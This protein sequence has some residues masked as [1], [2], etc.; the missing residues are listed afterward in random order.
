MFKDMFRTPPVLLFTLCVAISGLSIYLQSPHE[1]N[2]HPGTDTLFSVRRAYADLNEIASAPHS[3]GTLEHDKVMQ[4]IISACQ[5]AGLAAQIQHS[6]SIRPSNGAVTAADIHNIIAVRKG[7]NN[8]KAVLVMAHYDSQPNTFGAG[9]NGVGVAAMIETARVLNAI[10]Q[11]RNDVI[12]LF[13]DGEECGLLGAKAFIEESPLMRQLGIVLNFEGRG[14]S[15]I[16]TMFEVNP[17]NGWIVREYISGAAHPFANSLSFEIYK[18]LPNDTDYSLF[19]KAGISGLN[20]A[21][22]EGFVN[23]HSMTDSRE[24][25]DLNTLRQE[26][27]NM[28]SLVKHFGSINIVRTKEKD[29]SYFNIIGSYMIHYPSSWDLV[30]IILAFSV[31]GFQTIKSI[32]RGQLTIKGLLAGAGV[33]LMTSIIIYFLSGYLLGLFKLLSPFNSRFYA[34]NTYSS[35]YYFFS[36]TVF[37]VAVFALSYGYVSKKLNTLS[38]VLGAI[39][40]EA[41][42]MPGLFL[43]ASTASYFLCLPLLSVLIGVAILRWENTGEVLQKWASSVRQM[44]FSVIALLIMSP[45]IYMTYVAFGLSS[46]LQ[47]A[48]VMLCLLLGLLLPMLMPVVKSRTYLIPI[49]GLILFLTSISLGYF[50]GKFTSVQPLRTNLQYILNVDSGK[51]EWVSDFL[52]TD[53]WNHQFFTQARIHGLPDRYG[54]KLLNAAPILP[55]QP[56]NVNIQMDTV[57]EG[58][59]KLA[60]YFKPLEHITSIRVQI[61]GND[62]AGGVMINGKATPKGLGPFY[63][64][65]YYA[66]GK[67]GM[68]IEFDL[69]PSVKFEMMVIDRRIGIPSLPGYSNM[70]DNIVH[71]PS[72]NTS[73]VVKSYKL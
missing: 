49:A 17:A 30:F 10:G 68:V 20:N 42:L 13:T 47:V 45:V 65:E 66:P 9:D 51:A 7:S 33:F 57:A 73:E 31:L 62:P 67:N 35:Y 11:L 15:G 50:N 70:P 36:V 22:I 28:V 6:T 4:Y 5:T 24:R 25:L 69:K 61:T 14:N 43:M 55:L 59:R 63:M 1:G 8:S 39:L 3:I 19:K 21:F 72:G 58:R 41:L 18:R 60:L 2:N 16:P 54:L 23:Y 32:R 12:F 37:S 27:E 44:G 46:Q 64:V 40:G 34:G 29:I 52:K 48:V 26:G 38:I 71:G 53:S 56:T